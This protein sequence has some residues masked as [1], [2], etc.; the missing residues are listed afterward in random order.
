MDDTSDVEWL[1]YISSFEQILAMQ[2]RHG[3][4]DL[5]DY[6]LTL[7][8]ELLQK[9]IPINEHKLLAGSHI[10][11]AAEMISTRRSNIFSEWDG[12]VSNSPDLVGVI[13]KIFS[14][15]ISAPSL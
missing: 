9:D 10:L 3:V 11:S 4:I 15:P 12:D 8:M 6:D 2:E 5:S 13:E 1:T 14:N 7:T